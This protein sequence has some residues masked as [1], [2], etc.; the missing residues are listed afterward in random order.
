[1][2]GKK[3]KP[4]NLTKN[5]ETAKVVIPN[6]AAEAQGEVEQKLLKLI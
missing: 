1:M 2:K 3:T 6:T 5:T 4:K